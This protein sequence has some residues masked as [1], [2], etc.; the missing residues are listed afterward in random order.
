MTL[1]LTLRTKTVKASRKKYNP[2]KSQEGSDV[3]LNQSGNQGQRS[4]SISP[5]KH[6]SDKT[7]KKPAKNQDKDDDNTS[8]KKDQK[9]AAP[10]TKSIVKA[11]SGDEDE[12]IQ[13]QKASE[14]QQKQVDFS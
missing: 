1:E 3:M 5:D 10:A 6:T 13:K 4:I 12:K 11:G 9:P 2:N 8:Q 7:D 14:L